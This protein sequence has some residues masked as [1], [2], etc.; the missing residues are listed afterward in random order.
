MKCSRSGASGLDKAF[1]LAFIEFDDQGEFFDRTQLETV[2]SEIRKKHQKLVLITYIHGWQNNASIDGKENILCSDKAVAEL[3]TFKEGARGAEGD[4]QKF[5][6]FV[7]LIANSRAVRER[8]CHVM[9]VYLGWRGE[10][11]K[12]GS[13]PI[14]KYALLT[15]PRT[16][17]FFS[18]KASATRLGDSSDIGMALESLRVA[19]RPR[20]AKRTPTDPITVFMGHSFG[21]KVLEQAVAQWITRRY[22]EEWAKGEKNSKVG[23]YSADKFADLVLFLNP[24]SES[25]YSRRIIN[26]LKDMGSP[27][28]D[29]T[30]CD[31]PGFNRVAPWFVT[32]TSE[33]DFATN[34]A[35][36]V[37]GMLSQPLFTGYRKYPDGTN[38][39]YFFTRSSPNV[40]W[41]RNGRVRVKEG[42]FWSNANMTRGFAIKPGSATTPEETTSTREAQRSFELNLEGFSEPPELRN[43]RLI[44][45]ENQSVGEIEFEENKLADGGHPNRTRYWIL[46]V[47]RRIM[48]NHPD[49]WGPNAMNVYAS[50]FHVVA[51]ENPWNPPVNSSQPNLGRGGAWFSAN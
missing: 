4:V 17:T 29:G 21:G 8:G 35:F 7:A 12:N 18:R 34:E 25:I 36:P 30:N 5:K 41:L 26:M 50:L 11:I 16:L 15:V 3:D 14:T 10:L 24:A 49:V 51:M 47:D 20:G 45:L 6:Q 9:G 37:G 31:K 43:Q 2:L 39:R 42:Y 13:D 33:S 40:A 23:G 38:Q 19:A 46:K 22:A 1:K 44:A 32:L 28:S 27:N 48:D